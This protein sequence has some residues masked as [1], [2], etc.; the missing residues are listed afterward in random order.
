MQRTLICLTALGCLL[1]IACR[2]SSNADQPQSD[3]SKPAPPTQPASGPGGSE[4]PHAGVTVNHFGEG[5]SE[6]WVFLPKEPTPKEAPV[7][8]FLHGWGGMKPGVYGGW[9]R[10]LVRRGNI[11]MYPRYQSNLRDRPDDMIK[12]AYQTV[13]TAWKKLAES[14]DIQ[15]RRDHIAYFGHSLGGILAANFASRGPALGLPPTG[16]VLLVEP[17]NGE[18]M[19]KRDDRVMK[20]ESGAGIPA[21]ALVVAMV[22]D[23]DKLAAEHAAKKIMAAIP[24]VPR[25][26]KN[27]LVVHSDSHT[28]PALAADH[29]SPACPDSGI[30]DEHDDVA[31]DDDLIDLLGETNNEPKSAD[32]RPGR[33]PGLLRKR[34]EERRTQ[35]QGAA[36]GGR[37]EDRKPVTDALD[38]GAYW[39]VGDGLLDACFAGKNRE[40]AVGDGAEVRSIGKCSDGSSAA[41]LEPRSIP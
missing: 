2:A 3:S 5:D 40:Y 38:W 39:K 32:D 37:R 28:S 29:L 24:Q 18:P 14:P 41:S 31:G 16:A 15:P 11:V 6:C 35:R 34:L 10:H 20:I 22:G 25:A 21:D 23:A 13:Q 7:V 9:I 36:G 33:R 30:T 12:N 17:S 19:I 1:G 4:Y 27:Y 26:N 8:V